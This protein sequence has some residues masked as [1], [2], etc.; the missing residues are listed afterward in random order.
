MPNTIQYAT[1]FQK[2][3]VKSF[4][5]DALTGW[6]DENTNLA[7]YHGGAEIKIP[8]ITMQGLGDYD[9]AGGKGAPEGDVN[10][11]YETLKMKKDRARGFTLDE[12]DVDETNF[13]LTMGMVMGEF[14]RTRVV[15]EVDAYR[16][17]TAATLAGAE[18]Q[19]TYTP[20]E[21]SVLKE[22]TNDLLD[23]RA[24]VG[25]TA[26]IVIHICSSAYKM[27]IGSEKLT[28]QLNVG[29]FK[30]GEISQQVRTLDGTP[31][32]VTPDALM[33]TKFDY[34]DGKT[35]SQEDGGFEKASDAKAIN[36]LIIARACPIAPC[37][38]DAVRTFD[39]STYQKARAWH[40]DYR[41]YHDLW[42][43]KH[44]LDGVFANLGA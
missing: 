27:L 11:S 40:S 25:Y 32:I 1:I 28:R 38:Q 6:M 2:E 33:Q 36:W 8:S 29:E 34:K 19:R 18:R 17:S 4:V 9:R 15:P 41:K 43:P 13:S 31:M 24:K 10:F 30:H 16:L 14:Q 35:P 20:A 23:V 5:R 21:A 37:K 3:L 12:M 7:I 42:I 39:P 44:K 26:P 22:L